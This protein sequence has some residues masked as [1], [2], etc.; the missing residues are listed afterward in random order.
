MKV[1]CI[2]DLSWKSSS[3]IIWILEKRKT[4]CLSIF[5]S[6]ILTSKVGNWK[7]ISIH[8]IFSASFDGT[9]LLTPGQN[10]INTPY[11]PCWLTVW[12]H[13]YLSPTNHYESLTYYAYRC[14]MISC[15]RYFR[16]LELHKTS[17]RIQN[18]ISVV[19]N[20]QSKPK[21]WGVSPW[22]KA[23]GNKVEGD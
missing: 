18:E 19:Y 6:L 14:F 5:N 16:S 7:P 21:F 9:A 3:P 12:K 22:C 20:R 23:K 8:F 4:C 2:V 11:I 17:L 10:D 15:L 1:H 13:L